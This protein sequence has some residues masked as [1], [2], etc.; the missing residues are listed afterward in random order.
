[1]YDKTNI[2][3]YQLISNQTLNGQNT[4]CTYNNITLY[5][6]SGTYTY[7]QENVDDESYIVM[8]CDNIDILTHAIKTLNNP[9]ILNEIKTFL[10]FIVMITLFILYELYRR[11]LWGFKLL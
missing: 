1:N 2:N 10:A 11:E 5:N 9:G 4:L 3:Q 7:Y 8:T 6:K